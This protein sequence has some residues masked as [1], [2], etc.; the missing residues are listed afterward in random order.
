MVSYGVFFYLVV[1]LSHLQLTYLQF[2]LDGL[3]LQR[4]QRGAL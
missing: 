1:N 4:L 2:Q 3:S